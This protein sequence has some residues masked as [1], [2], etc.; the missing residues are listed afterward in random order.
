MTFKFMVMKCVYK[1]LLMLMMLMGVSAQ[2]QIS[3]FKAFRETKGAVTSDSKEMYVWGPWIQSSTT[4]I[5]NLTKHAIFVED[6]NTNSKVKYEIFDKPQKWIVKKNYKYINFECME[7]KSLE[8]YYVRLCEYDS[9]EFKI[10][11]MSP[12]NAVRY[13]VIYLKE[14]DSVNINFDDIEES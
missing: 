7:S 3:S 13:Q 5:L 8:K 2:A 14:N 11:V 4:F 10:T 9:G 1:I 6:K 12:K